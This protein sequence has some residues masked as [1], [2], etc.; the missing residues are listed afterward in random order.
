MTVHYEQ[1]SI[2]KRTAAHSTRLA[3]FGSHSS[4]ARSNS[5]MCASDPRPWLALGDLLL[6][7]ALFRLIVR[8]RS[9]PRPWLAL[10]DLLLGSAHFGLSGDLRATRLHTRPPG[11]ERAYVVVTML[12]TFETQ[13]Q[14]TVGTH[15]AGIQLVGISKSRTRRKLHT[16][17]ANR[18]GPGVSV[19]VL[20][21]SWAGSI[22]HSPRSIGPIRWGRVTQMLVKAFCF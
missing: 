13:K 4:V 11:L 14:F 15:R 18:R 5:G 21:P 1:R 7:S 17:R 16:V 19:V 10:G 6:R 12:L 22:P 9:D 20:S 8:F 3:L 2:H